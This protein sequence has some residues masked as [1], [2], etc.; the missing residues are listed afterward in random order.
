[1]SKKIVVIDDE[2]DILEILRYNLTKAGYNIKTFN[3]PVKALDYIER[4]LCDMIITDW[5]M[6]E[7]EGIDLCRVIKYSPEL[8][9]IPIVMITCKDEEIDVVTALELGAEDFLSK[10][11]GVK[12]LQTRI[13]KIFKRQNL[14]EAVFDK[15][16]IIRNNL[17]INTEKFTVTI[18]NKKLD[19]TNCEFRLLKLLAAKPGKVFS[20]SDIIDKIN[21]DEH[22]ISE[23][24]IDVQIV[25]LR[26]KMGNS[27]NLIE[28]VRSVGYRFTENYT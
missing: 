11:F 15:N 16:I 28:T 22:I 27:K 21:S 6:P 23:R 10:P 2:P 12:E 19:L 3:N 26:K 5:L 14:S 13:K 17:K 18:E 24:A 25:G 1:M 20:R 4:F 9:H 7:M 8:Q